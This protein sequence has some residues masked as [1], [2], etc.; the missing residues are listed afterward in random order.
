M[1]KIYLLLGIAILIASCNTKSGSTKEEN[2][3][4]EEEII[5][6]TSMNALDVD[7]VYVGIL[8]TASGE[9]MEVVVTLSGNTYKKTVTYVGKS[10]EPIETVGEF[11]WDDA[12]GPIITFVGEEAPN[13]YIIGEDKLISLDMDGEVITGDLADMYVLKK[14]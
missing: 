2:A 9:G 3:V 14:K 12:S 13:K 10:E 4:E 8:P 5:G 1:K 7:G 6:D 11:I